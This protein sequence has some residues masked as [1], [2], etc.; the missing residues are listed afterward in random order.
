MDRFAFYNLSE[1]IPINENK[2]PQRFNR[3]GRIGI[4]SNKFFNLSY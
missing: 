1:E 2:K 3:Y 4:N